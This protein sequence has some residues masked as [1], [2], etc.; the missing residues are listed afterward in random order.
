MMHVLRDYNGSFYN[1]II[2]TLYIHQ[3]IN[4]E[5]LQYYYTIYVTETS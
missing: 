1:F 4:G 2:I 5:L 3:L